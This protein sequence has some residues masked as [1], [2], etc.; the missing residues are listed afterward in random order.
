MKIF[1]NCLKLNFIAQRI[2]N[3]AIAVICMLVLFGCA[4]V[5]VEKNIVALVD[6]DPI[7]KGDIE[8][9]IEIAHRRE[10]LAAT[11]NINITEFVQELID[12]RLIVQEARRMGLQNDPQINGKVFSYRLRESVTKLYNEEILQKAK[13]SESDINEYYRKNYEILGLGLIETDNEE[14]TAHAL[15]LL[16]RGSDFTDLAR[17]HSTHVSSEKGGM[18][19]LE[20]RALSP[21]LDHAVMS[22]QSGEVSEVTKSGNKYY[23]I[24]LIDRSEAPDEE[25]EKVRASIEGAVKRKK[26]KQL[27]NEYIEYL[28]K[29]Y[30][31]DIDKELLSSIN[32][33]SREERTQWSGDKRALVS[34][35]DS[36]LTADAFVRGINV[37]SQDEHAKELRIKQWIDRNLV[38]K[39]ALSRNYEQDADFQNKVDRYANK[40]IKKEFIDRYI[41]P[42][43]RISGEELQNYY[44]QHKEDYTRPA[45]YRIQQITV[46]SIDDGEDILNSLNKGADFS[47]LAKTGSVDR[48]GPKG[49]F[50]GWREKGQLTA[51]IKNIID[52]MKPG[53]VSP[54]LEDGELYRIIKLQDKVYETVEDF[55]KVERFVRK[56]LFKEKYKEL[57]SINVDKLKKDAHIEI[58]NDLILSLQEL[59]GQK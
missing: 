17:E 19:K 8:Y 50:L 49:G 41:K 10:K 39:E 46:R 5:T 25:L 58:K 15:E 53:D 35:G 47:W 20:R 33:M 6:G 28:Y 48:F 1:V 9:A 57:Y 45:Q 29:K 2:S 59:F 18:V 44:L 38:D 14:K 7:T 56:S 34:I 30:P 23:I 11:R 26:T 55:S 4:S 16:R 36:V 54:V 24:K 21:E 31:P 37:R 51:P 13:V 22:L 52:T 43:I 42:Q 40:L 27:G 32:H 3:I 12:D